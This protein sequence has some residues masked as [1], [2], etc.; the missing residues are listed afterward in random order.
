LL[1]TDG[2][3]VFDVATNDARVKDGL[4]AAVW[5]AFLSGLAGSFVVVFVL[6]LAYGDFNA[7]MIATVASIVAGIFLWRAQD[8][9]LW[10]A[11]AGVLVSGTLGVALMGLYF[12]PAVP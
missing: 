6:A 9:L 10:A 4:G 1:C 7:F 3:K 12:A 2:R 8:R 5:I 11:G